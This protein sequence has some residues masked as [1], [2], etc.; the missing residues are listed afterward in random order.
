MKNTF[1]VLSK[2][3]SLFCN[4]ICSNIQY[5]RSKNTFTFSKHRSGK[6]KQNSRKMSR[7]HVN[8]SYVCPTIWMLLSPLAALHLSSPRGKTRTIYTKSLNI[9]R[10]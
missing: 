7:V 10:C 1:D 8:H 9:Q 6:A 3:A 2:D 5:N 4:A